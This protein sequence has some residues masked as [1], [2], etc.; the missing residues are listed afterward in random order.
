[1][2]ETELTIVDAPDGY[3]HNIANT[4]VDPGFVACDAINGNSFRATGREL[5]LVWNQGAAAEVITINSNPASRTGRNGPITT[6]SI[7]A[8]TIEAFQIFPKDGWE[9]GG[10]ITMA[11]SSDHL[12]IAVVRFPVQA[13]G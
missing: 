4:P 5:V 3:E 11:M 7:A 10:L 1:M 12:Y 2:A 6:A 9:D 8:G 13:A